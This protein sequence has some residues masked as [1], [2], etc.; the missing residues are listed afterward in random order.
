MSRHAYKDRIPVTGG[1]RYP[2]VL[3]EFAIGV[4]GSCASAFGDEPQT[5][6]DT[7]HGA[8]HVPYCDL[9]LDKRKEKVAYPIED[10]Y[11]GKKAAPMEAP[12]Q[13]TY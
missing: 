9:S 5:V 10:G 8:V 2:R 12:H 7:V 13:K 4:V 3:E 11:P 6:H 1:A